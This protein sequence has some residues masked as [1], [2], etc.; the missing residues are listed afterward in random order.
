M[1]RCVWGEL[2]RQ[3]GGGGGELIGQGSV[4]VGGVD[5]VDKAAGGGGGLMEQFPDKSDELAYP[6]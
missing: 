1:R 2:T 5:K 6:T 3:R 4:G